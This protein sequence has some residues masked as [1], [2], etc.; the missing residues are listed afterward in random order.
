MKRL[1][2]PNAPA[3]LSFEHYRKRNRIEA[4]TLNTLVKPMSMLIVALK[5]VQS[6]QLE[7]FSGR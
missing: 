3:R 7:R 1:K 4:L 5:L 2:C 6:S